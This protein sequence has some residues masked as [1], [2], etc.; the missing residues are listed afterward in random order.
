MTL[1]AGI[2]SNARTY[3]VSLI[4]TRNTNLRYRSL[5]TGV[6][7]KRFASSPRDRVGQFPAVR[8]IRRGGQIGGIPSRAPSSTHWAIMPI[9]RAEAAV[10]LEF[11]NTP[12]RGP[13]RHEAFLRDFDDLSSAFLNVVKR[14]QIEWPDL[15]RVV[16]AR[17][18]LK[19]DRR[20]VFVNDSAP[21]ADAEPTGR[22]FGWWI[23]RDGGRHLCC[24][25]PGVG[26][27]LARGFPQPQGPASTIAAIR[28]HKIFE[29]RLAAHSSTP[30]MRRP[31][32][33]V[34]GT[35]TSVPPGPLQ[36]PC[37]SCCDA[38]S[39]DLPYR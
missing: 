32:T 1:A 22:H 12:V 9:S 34:T 24:G 25:W 2:K 6:Q 28:T 17:H 4:G 37:R 29:T 23:E 39:R 7:M 16:T 20:D 27:G 19:N 30:G 14:K 8:Q 3:F 10:A 33:A 31:I 26:R 18:S 35:G 21:G 11:R 13:G 38:T 36:S 5:V 15:A